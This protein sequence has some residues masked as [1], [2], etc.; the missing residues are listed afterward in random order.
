MIELLESIGVSGFVRLFKPI[1]GWVTVGFSRINSDLVGC[2][3]IRGEG[4]YDQDYDL[5]A[6]VYVPPLQSVRMSDPR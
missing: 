2:C 3:G 4:D 1:A 6:Y 5:E